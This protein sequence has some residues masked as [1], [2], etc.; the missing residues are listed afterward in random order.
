MIQLSEQSRFILKCIAEG[1][2]IG[3][4]LQHQPQFTVS[5]IAK[6]AEDALRLDNFHRETSSKKTGDTNLRTYE[7]WTKDEDSTLHMMLS[8]NVAVQDIAKKL[9]RHPMIIRRR[10]RQLKLD[11]L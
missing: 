9:E 10:I 8:N 5:D 4:I 1:Q 7:V 6:A 2:T 11:D 3:E